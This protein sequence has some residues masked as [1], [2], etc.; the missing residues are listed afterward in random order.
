M[1]RNYRFRLFYLGEGFPSHRRLR[2]GGPHHGRDST[3]ISTIV[4]EEG[5]G[6]HQAH[7][8]RRQWEDH[9]VI[10]R[11]HREGDSEEVGVVEADVVDTATGHDHIRDLGAGRLVEVLRDRHIAD[12]CR[13]H[14]R[15]DEDMGD[16]TVRRGEVGAGEAV[17]VEAVEVGEA[18]ATAHMEAEVL[19]TEARAETA[20]SR[21]MR[22]PRIAQPNNGTMSF[23]IVALCPPC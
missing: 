2:E 10:A 22:L 21:C 11:D 8:A 14:H 18:R 15:R 19:E 12:R 7:I 9:R 23:V 16:E 17:V 3:T 13:G 5:E 1:E 20:D 6:D 4:E